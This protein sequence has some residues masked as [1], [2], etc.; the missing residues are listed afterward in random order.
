[1][2]EHDMISNISYIMRLYPETTEKILIKHGADPS[3]EYWTD[4]CDIASA[5]D[6]LLQWLNSRYDRNDQET[7]LDYHIQE[8]L[9]WH[10]VNESVESDFEIPA[11][12][13][14]Y[15]EFSPNEV[16]YEELPDA[17]DHYKELKVIAEL[18]AKEQYEDALANNC[19]DFC[20]LVEDEIGK[21][22]LVTTAGLRVYPITLEE[23]QDCVGN[24][25]YDD[26]EDLEE[27]AEMSDAQRLALQELDSALECGEVTQQ[28]YEDG[29]NVQW[30]INFE[31]VVLFIAGIDVPL[32]D[33]KHVE[34]GDCDETKFDGCYS[35]T[36][37]NGDVKKYGWHDFDM[38][39]SLTCIDCNEGI[40]SDVTGITPSGLTE[41]VDDG[42]D[43]PF[44][45]TERYVK[46]EFV[47]FNNYQGAWHLEQTRPKTKHIGNYKSLEAAKAA[48][49]A[50]INK[51]NAKNKDK[52]VQFGVHSFTSDSIVFRGT[53]DE[54]AEYINK[55]GLENDAEIYMIRPDDRHYREVSD[56]LV[57]DYP[58]GDAENFIQHPM[59][60]NITGELDFAVADDVKVYLHRGPGKQRE[61]YIVI[62]DKYVQHSF[63][64][65]ET[66]KK[67]LEKQK[68]LKE[69][70]AKRFNNGD[71][72]YV[73]VCN[74]QGRVRKMISPDVVEVELHDN[75][76]YPERIDRYYIDEVELQYSNDLDES[77]SS[78][79]YLTETWNNGRRGHPVTLDG[80][81]SNAK[82]D[83][84][85]SGYVQIDLDWDARDSADYLLSKGYKVEEGWDLDTY[86][87]DFSWS[88]YFDVELC[89]SLEYEYCLHAFVP[90]DESISF[91]YF[92]RLLKKY[93]MSLEYIEY[94]DRFK[95][96]SVY[97]TAEGQVKEH[98]QVTFEKSNKASSKSAVHADAD[99]EP[100]IHYLNGKYAKDLKRPSEG[101][102][103]Y[104][105]D[106]YIG[107]ADS[108]KEAE[109]MIQHAR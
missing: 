52:P 8:I 75:G 77:A 36:F 70:L 37:H 50:E 97:L 63:S 89:V 98:P 68:L 48:G 83:R 30:D 39:G 24:N 96:T 104:K 79:S 35:V 11:P 47:I 57:E 2:N 71:V 34:Y 66:V 61:F 108:P 6:E 23:I 106:V 72:V 13:N 65:L 16:N 103:V 33:V 26:Y 45:W 80:L 49:D 81:I 27:A 67:Y 14:Q 7:E 90:H 105:N 56:N 9:G 15:Y 38:T 29:Q 44:D 85:N 20:W 32:K 59:N 4:G 18:Y 82:N 64:K 95:R 41:D 60:Y 87:K 109:I 101:Y 84:V 28:E 3:K 46:D 69:S 5:Y 74:R 25:D 88:E 31:D 55:N 100:F 12:Y 99:N 10:D 53:E 40:L 93:G 86:K 22:L 1:M 62:G 78:N 91:D 51:R 94:Y 19:L 102:V 92:Q 73:T 17:F 21:L 43:K 107:H 42:W 76:V 54:C 58:R